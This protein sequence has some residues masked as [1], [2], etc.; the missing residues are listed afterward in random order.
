[1][2]GNKKM[3]FVVETFFNKTKKSMTFIDVEKAYCKAVQTI[4]NQKVESIAEL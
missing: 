3:L 2:V 1:M 4:N